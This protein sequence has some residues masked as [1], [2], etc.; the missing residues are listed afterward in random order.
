MGFNP[1]QSNLH[2]S[3]W[4]IFPFGATL[5]LKMLTWPFEVTKS[6]ISIKVLS[7]N[8]FKFERKVGNMDECD[9]PDGCVSPPE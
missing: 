4:T 5:F 6:D 3:I 2:E 8:G 7:I 9:A 1:K